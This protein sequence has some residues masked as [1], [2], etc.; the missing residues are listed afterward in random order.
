MM[1]EVQGLKLVFLVKFLLYNISC[2]ELTKIKNMQLDYL[3]DLQ[4]NYCLECHNQVINNWN[5]FMADMSNYKFKKIQQKTIL[6]DLSVETKLCK[7]P[8]VELIQTDTVFFQT[9]QSLLTNI[10]DIEQNIK[11]SGCK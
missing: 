1:Y 4:R 7:E 2:Q 11:Y 10:S 9:G 8:I 5:E 6:T 3:A